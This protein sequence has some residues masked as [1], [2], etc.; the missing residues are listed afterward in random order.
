M[1]DLGLRIV[2]RAHQDDGTAE[3]TWPPIAGA[4][5][6]LGS[7]GTKVDDSTTTP[8]ITDADGIATIDAVTVRVEADGFHPYVGVYS[9]PNL[10][11]PPLPVSL[12][13]R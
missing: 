9:R 2:V 12:R 5:V 13:R 1:M 3:E 10:Q 11:G 8:A 7:G 6:A 4:R